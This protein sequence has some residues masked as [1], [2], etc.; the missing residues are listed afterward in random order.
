MPDPPSID[1]HE[2]TD[3]GS[4]NQRAVLANRADLVEDIYSPKPSARV[5]SLTK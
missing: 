2:V 1:Q 4:I 5:I 3:K